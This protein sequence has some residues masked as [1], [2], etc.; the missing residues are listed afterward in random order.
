LLYALQGEIYTITP[1][2][3]IS[4]IFSKKKTKKKKMK[5]AP[6]NH[7]VWNLDNKFGQVSERTERS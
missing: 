7:R 6:I 4:P 2:T 5:K 3:R 1:P